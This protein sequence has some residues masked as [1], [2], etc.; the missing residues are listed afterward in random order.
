MR[1]PFD[2]IDKGAAPFGMSGMIDYWV[3]INYASADA[4]VTDHKGEQTIGVA[5]RAT[6]SGTI[7][8][9]DRHDVT[10]TIVLAANE[11]LPTSVKTIVNTGSTPGMGIAVAIAP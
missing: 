2:M 6:S 5:I 3:S 7:V 11:V 8:F 9:K 10:R 1:D 4:N